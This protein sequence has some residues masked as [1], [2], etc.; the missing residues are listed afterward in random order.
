[1]RNWACV[2]TAGLAMGAAGCGNSKPTKPSGD[3]DGGAGN[4]DGTNAL[5]KKLIILHTNDLHSHF[6]GQAPE[7]DYTPLTTEDDMTTGGLARL[8]TAIGSARTAAAT[9]DTPV[10]LLDAGDFM[11]GTLFE[12]LALAEAPELK[13]MQSVGYDATTIGNHE[14]DWTPAGLAGIL[15]RAKAE[16]VTVPVLASNMKFDPDSPDDDTLNALADQGFIKTKLVKTVGETDTTSGLKIGFFGLLGKD[17]VQ[18]TP[19][20][21]PL[22]FDDIEVAAAR[23]VAELRDEDKVDLVIA[24]SHSGINE[25]GKGED[26]DLAAAVPGIDI[27]IS[28]HTHDTLAEPVTVGK[29]LIVTA[30][31]YGR[32]LGQLHVSV[33]PAASPGGQATVALDGY[34]LQSIDDKIPGDPD[35]HARVQTMVETLDNQISRALPNL[36]YGK[37]VAKTGGDLLT[38]GRGVESPLGNLVADAYRRVGAALQPSDPPQIA[39]EANGQLRADILKG[40]TGDIWFADLFRV[41]P[42]GIG[43]N[44]VPGFPLVTFYLNAKDIQSGLELGAASELVPND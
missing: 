28:G 7:R 25:A 26:A 11:M 36:T 38:V 17:A 15:N 16:Q 35:T 31:S 37:V 4:P 21:A 20:R 41:T 18:V 32:L 2:L 43:P 44:Q 22:T 13:F 10:L 3:G 42:L 9:T 33:T 30:G 40:T 6:M 8:A 24:L 14:L 1:M 34:T 39:V 12:L 5:A 29:T 27:I 19:Q 23:M